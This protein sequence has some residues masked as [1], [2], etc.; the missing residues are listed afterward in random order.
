MEILKQEVRNTLLNGAAIFFPNRQTRR[1]HLFT[2]MVI[3]Y[4]KSTDSIS[5]VYWDN[6]YQSVFSEHL[7]SFN[8]PNV[9]VGLASAVEPG[10]GI[11]KIMIEKNKTNNN[12][13]KMIQLQ[14][15][16]IAYLDK[17]LI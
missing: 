10:K 13:F 6:I 17:Q 11:F 2:M 1:N 12:Y 14:I 16:F 8:F 15:I 9:T 7:V 5:E 3:I 4:V